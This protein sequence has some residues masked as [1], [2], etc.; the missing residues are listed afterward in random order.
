MIREDLIWV[1]DFTGIAAAASG[2]V[3]R[4]FFIFIVMI[5]VL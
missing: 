4:I 5:L 2:I 3:K 1:F